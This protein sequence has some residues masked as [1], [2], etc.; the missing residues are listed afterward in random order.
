MSEDA[1]DLVIS[2]QESKEPYEILRMS[3]EV[4]EGGMLWLVQFAFLSDGTCFKNTIMNFCTESEKETGWKFVPKYWAD[5]SELYH[6]APIQEEKGWDVMWHPE[7]KP[8][9]IT[10]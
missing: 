4:M 3:K 1:L 6:M 2:Q 8:K 9:T 10:H 7:Y 5:I